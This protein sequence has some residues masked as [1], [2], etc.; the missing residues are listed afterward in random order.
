M[1]AAL[2]VAVDAGFDGGAAAWVL[3]LPGCVATAR[4]EAEA[5]AAVPDRIRAYRGWTGEAVP[6]EANP[7]VVERVETTRL[8]DGY[9]VNATFE[10]D[11]EPM[12]AEAVLA[13]GR[14]VA[15]AHDRLLKAFTANSGDEAILAHAIRAAIWLSTRTEPDQ[16]A[17]AFPP[18]V[19]PRERVREAIPFVDRYV[20]RMADGDGV[21]SRVDG[22]GEEWT[23]RKV[24]RR[25]IYH[26]IDHA[27][28]FER[29][30]VRA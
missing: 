21:R 23:V 14:R 19:P 26:A 2:P 4:T 16:S 22:K 11:R 1:T 18:D 20:A 3:D 29:G 25:L 10:A 17:I 24:I 13:A 5:L 8:E 15:A 12:D 27:E 28:Q 30:E 7:E 9:E 6:Q